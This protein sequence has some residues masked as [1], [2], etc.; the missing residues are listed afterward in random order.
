MDADTTAYYV[1]TGLVTIATCLTVVDQLYPGVLKPTPAQ[2]RY[3]SSKELIR[4]SSSVRD[5]ARPTATPVPTVTATVTATPIPAGFPGSSLSW[6]ILYFIL[7]SLLVSGTVF[8]CKVAHSADAIR[9]EQNVT[10]THLDGFNVNFENLNGDFWKLT[11]RL[12]IL[13][14]M[15]APPLAAFTNK[16]NVIKGTLDRKSKVIIGI[17][18]DIVVKQL[19]IVVKKLDGISRRQEACRRDICGKI[20]MGNKSLHDDNMK[21]RETLSAVLG[22]VTT[23][24]TEQTAM[25]QA[26][27][28]FVESTGKS[29]VDLGTAIATVQGDVAAVNGKL[30][31]NQSALV[32]IKDDV[33]ETREDLGQGMKM[34]NDQF[35]AIESAMTQIQ[36]VVGEHTESLASL[37]VNVTEFKTRVTGFGAKL[38]HMLPRDL[39]VQPFAASLS[40]NKDRGH[41]V[42]PRNLVSSTAGWRLPPTS[43]RLLTSSDPSFGA[44]TT[45]VEGGGFATPTA[46]PSMTAFETPSRPDAPVDT[47]TEPDASTLHQPLSF[48]S[49]HQNFSIDPNDTLSGASKTSPKPTRSPDVPVDTPTKPGG[50]TLVPLLSQGSF[51]VD[52]NGSLVGACKTSLELT[53]RP[54]EKPDTTLPEVWTPNGVLSASRPQCYRTFGITKN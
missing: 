3:P 2:F 10:N 15:V 35:G 47:P 6:M 48:S 54:D 34:I 33:E 16:L 12:Q 8:A 9:E 14:R 5:F 11:S 29:L 42:G 26:L 39:T 32:H 18:A 27:D 45:F 20:S 52:P 40:Q 22:L 17:L 49:E 23:V 4:T 25:R 7:L 36:Q 21:Q 43:T 51:S 44:S 19:K 37:V 46:G 50:L 31:E 41:P 24:A 53:R 38:V 30:V 1:V 28:G 13:Q